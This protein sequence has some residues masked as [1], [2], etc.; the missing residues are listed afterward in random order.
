MVFFMGNTTTKNTATLPAPVCQSCGARFAPGATPGMH[1][2]ENSASHA[3]VMCRGPY[4][5][6]VIP[7]LTA[8]TK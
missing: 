4:T 5:V 3:I 7:S 8:V 1:P 6:A 2:D